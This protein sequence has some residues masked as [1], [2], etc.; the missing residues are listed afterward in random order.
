M[1]ELKADKQPIGK[2]DH[3]KPFTTHS[4]PLSISSLFLFTDGYADQF[5]GIKG[6]K[7]KYKPFMELLLNYSKLTMAEQKNKLDDA[8]ENWKGDI[9]QN[10]D[11]CIIGVR[12]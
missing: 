11:I 1:K 6:K 4:L 8:I 5:G 3:R 9:E 7:F 10:D 2:S 12:I